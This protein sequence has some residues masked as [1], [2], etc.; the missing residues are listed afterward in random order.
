MLG[1]Y[2]S[3]SVTSWA[4][5]I[6]AAGAVWVAEAFNTAIEY[7]VDLVHPEW[8]EK[9]GRVKDLAAG[10]VLLISVSAALVGILIFGSHI[11]KM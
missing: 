6:L 4:L 2:F 9:A 1:F 10:A 3:L 11:V 8:H 5:L 7:L